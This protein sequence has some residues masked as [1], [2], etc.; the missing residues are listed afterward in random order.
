ML[1]E[2][3]LDLLQELLTYDPAQRISAADALNHPWFKE[4][5]QRQN[6]EWMPSYPAN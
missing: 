4:S 6:R 5:P 3:G 2:R 1:S